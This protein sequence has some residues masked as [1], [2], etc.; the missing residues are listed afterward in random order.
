M[1][2]HRP[3]VL[4]GGKLA[5]LPAGDTLAAKVQEVD[6]VDMTARE[7]LLAGMAVYCSA[8]LQ[9]MKAKSDDDTKANVLGLAVAAV[10]L[11]A[12]VQVQTDG[13]LELTDWT[14]AA[15]AAALVAGS[16]YYLD[17]T[18]GL[19]TATIPATGNLVY[20]GRAISPQKL[21]ISVQRAIRL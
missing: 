7:A 10:A 3:V 16:D 6:I 1:A 18:A 12:S 2:I 9:I 4:I 13:V 8:D 14:A 19:L 15:G 17:A 20:V 21:E 11:D 5:L